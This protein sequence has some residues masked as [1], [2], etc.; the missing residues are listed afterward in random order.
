MKLPKPTKAIL[1]V[2]GYGTRRLPVAKA[3][4]KCMLPLLN[5]PIIDYVVQDVVAAGVTDVYF[6]VSDDAT[7]LRDY[8][9]RDIE[10]E[11]YLQAKGKE[12]YIPLITPPKNVNFHFVE[13]DLS[14]RR[15]GSAVPLWLAGRYINSDE[16]FYYVAGDDTLWSADG[17]SEAAKLWEQVA[18][19]NSDG[20]LIGCQVPLEDVSKYGV[21]RLDDQGRYIELVEK[22]Q[23]QDAP[24][25][26]CN[27][28]KY[29]FSGI[30]LEYVERYM[31]QPRDAEYFITDVVNDFVQSRNSMV[32]RASDAV[33][34]DCGSL[35]KWVAANSYLLEHISAAG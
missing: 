1:P 14:D 8:Y 4:D 9:S 15:Y 19:T 21:F 27:V 16:S 34:L 5:R 31:Q 32:V 29:L 7:Q 23:P 28:S 25:T 24:S 2:A 26:L 13:Q 35:E 18:S 33:Y 10:L 3:V 17:S 22:P 20:G 12:Q 30:I 6:V 11:Q